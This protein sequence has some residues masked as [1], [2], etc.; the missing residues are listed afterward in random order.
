MS[1]DLQ[2]SGGV[3]GVTADLADMR[4]TAG[5]LDT[6][7]DVLR[8]LAGRVLAMVGDGDVAASA[9]LSP[10]TAAR[11]TAQL[12][13]AA[14]GLRGLMPAGLRLEASALVLQTTAELYE[15]VDAATLALQD[16]V[17][18]LQANLLGRA[19]LPLAVLALLASVVEEGGERGDHLLGELLAGDL[20]FEEVAEQLGGFPAGV[21]DELNELSME[22]LLTFPGVTDVALGNS[23]QL[24]AGLLG[25]PTWLGDVSAFPDDF[26][27]A[28]AA[29]LAFGGASFG[30]FDDGS[31][32]SVRPVALT[33]DQLADVDGSGPPGSIR[34]VFLGQGN[35]M[36]AAQPDGQGS[37]VRVVAVPQ[38][39]GST[40]WVVQVPGTQEWGPSAGGDLSDVTSNLLLEAEQEARLLEAVAEAMRQAGVQPT[41][42]VMMTGHSQGGIAAASFVANPTYGDA[43]NV[44]HVVTGGSPIARIPIPDDVQVLSL[45]HDT[46]PVPRLEGDPNPDRPNHTTVVTHV[47]RQADGRPFADVIGP[48]SSSLYAET[49]AAVDASDHASVD[50]FLD[51]A[52]GFLTGEGEV[53]DFEV[54]R[55]P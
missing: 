2:V 7:G 33:A 31:G 52:D 42:P 11:A 26:E 35:L 27:E 34:D 12:L 28:T 47:D 6:S 55:T 49:G 39:D 41:D 14:T 32:V 48:H 23:H 46:D 51:G 37:R 54:V 18:E 40:A 15:T 9:I 22:V 8:D 50:A 17:Q 20:S 43:Y 21:G 1:G 30:W 19:L 53:M 44:T 5:R 13:D 36:V 25:L 16:A 4:S 24:L 38:P 10:G 45:E 29:L 3:G